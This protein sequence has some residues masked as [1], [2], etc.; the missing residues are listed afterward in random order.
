MS[1]TDHSSAF[2]ASCSCGCCSCCAPL[3]SPAFS[4]IALSRDVATAASSSRACALLPIPWP[5]RVSPNEYHDPLREIKPRASP[6]LSRQAPH[7]GIC[8]QKK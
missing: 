3:V 4:R 2:S 6:V 5:R 7:F 1:S 8:L